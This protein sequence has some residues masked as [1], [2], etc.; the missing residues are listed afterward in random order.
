MIILRFDGGLGNQMYH[1][2][3]YRLLCKTYPEHKVVIDITS[4]NRGET[5]N[6]YELE[7]VFNQIN[8][9]KARNYDCFLCSNYFPTKSNSWIWVSCEKIYNRLKAKGVIR[10]SKY[11]FRESDW[12][13]FSNNV[14]L[15][16][17]K[18]YYLDCRWNYQFSYYSAWK[19]ELMKDFCFAQPILEKEILDIL[20]KYETVGIHVRAGDYLKSDFDILTEK[21]Y[22]CAI[23]KIREYVQNPYFVIVS[24]SYSYAKE[25]LGFLN[26]KKLYFV[27]SHQGRDS[28]QDMQIL[29][30]CRHNI[31]ANSTFSYWAAEINPNKEKIV[32]A[33]KRY[34][35]KQENFVVPPSWIKLDI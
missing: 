2:V 4:Y 18:T 27:H 1:Y 6:G 31:I 11:F 10:P 29:S 32:I 14:V 17:D 12:D 22:R 3:M 26:D 5:H 25:I 33:P 24:D 19:D 35:K 28:F 16:K 21:Y 23:D 7:T 15:N 34:S 8:L 20:Y 9:P 30:K 13:K